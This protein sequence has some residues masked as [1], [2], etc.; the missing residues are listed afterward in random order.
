MD[1]MGNRVCP[2]DA[3]LRKFVS[4][5]EGRTS[6]R[7]ANLST[8]Q[9]EVTVMV[10]TS[11]QFSDFFSQLPT[12]LF[13]MV[14]GAGLLLFVAFAWLVYFKPKRA[15][16]KLG[17]AEAVGNDVSDIRDDERYDMQIELPPLNESVSSSAYDIE[18]LPDLDALIDP[19]SLRKELPPVDYTPQPDRQMAQPP[20]AAPPEGVYRVKLNTGAV[21]EA[22]SV[23]SIL[24]DKRDGRLIVQMGDNAYRTLVESGDAKKDFVGVIKELSQV[25]NE[26]D[27]NPPSIDESAAEP[28]ELAP[29]MPV[30]KTAP[31]PP[32]TP[33]GKMP[34]DLPKFKIEDS[35]VPTRKGKYEPVPIPE[36]DIP[37]SIEA[38]LQYKLQHTPEYANRV[39]HVRSGV[40]GG[41]QIQVDN[42]YFDAVGDV[43][44]PEIRA[45][46]SATIEE[47][48]ERQ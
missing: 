18:E 42:S 13:V 26:Q 4:C 5:N 44:D 28:E 10:S 33:D 9:S 15:K 17:Q 47:W 23:V 22:E 38:Y 24:R 30:I 34:G 6:V 39:I 16:M 43:S 46:L 27:E 32:I 25:I 40:G 37:A 8:I 3:Q 14:C 35:V 12:Q 20:I 19:D 48:Q 41:V 7:I 1:A 36:L 21:V 45:F 29:P 11:D 31:P 2:V